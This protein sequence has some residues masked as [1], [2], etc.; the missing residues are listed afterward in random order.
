MRKKHLISINGKK[1]FKRTLS[2]LFGRRRK[3][4]L[5]KF[6]FGKFIFVVFCC[7]A[8]TLCKPKVVNHTCNRRK[9]VTNQCQ[10]LTTSELRTE[11]R[12]D[13]FQRTQSA[14]RSS[15][16]HLAAVPT[17]YIYSRAISLCFFFLSTTMVFAA[18]RTHFLRKKN[19]FI[20]IKWRSIHLSREKR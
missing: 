7:E 9:I 15:S 12:A 13:R 4:Q 11:P 14:N 2:Y 6:A 17:P 8:E 20:S 1:K 19:V 18:V 16:Q 10:E 3:V 5:T